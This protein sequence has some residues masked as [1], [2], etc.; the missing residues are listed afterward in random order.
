LIGFELDEDL[1]AALLNDFAHKVFVR[2]KGIAAKGLT[3][4][5]CFW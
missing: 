3:F 4:K 1:A 2:A 5:G